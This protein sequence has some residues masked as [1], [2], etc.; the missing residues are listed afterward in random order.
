[1]KM[2]SFSFIA[3]IIL[4]QLH[5]LSGQKYYSKAGHVQFVS[6]APLEKI[7][8]TNNSALIVIDAATG[9]M[10][11]SV[12][13]KGFKFEKALMQE[14]FNE[15]YMESHLYPKGIFSGTITN[16]KEINLGKDG[17]YTARVQGD[18]SLHGVKKAMLSRLPILILKYQ[19]WS[20]IIYL[21]RYK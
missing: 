2:K 13:M 9:R 14:H 3:I 7:T 10:D 19:K 1:M 20:R 15:N 16:M 4:L 17:T 21:K 12:L 8:A 5:S 18:L 11:L 6:D